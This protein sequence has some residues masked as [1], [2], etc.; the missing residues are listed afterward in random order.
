MMRRWMY[1]C[2]VVPFYAIIVY[3]LLRDVSPVML[4]GSGPMPSFYWSR[5]DP[6]P[7]VKEYSS[8]RS[9]YDFHYTVPY[10][11][12]A[13]LITSIGCGMGP[14][15]ARRVRGL[16]SHPFVGSSIATLAILLLAAL[17]SDTGDLLRLWGGPL[18][19]AHSFQTDSFV[20]LLKLLLPL[21]LLSGA[22]SF[23]ASRF[24]GTLITAQMS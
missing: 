18:M 9:Y 2:L 3:Y 5:P 12:A 22:V 20:A 13:F 11:V 8:R 15:V 7:D 19:L 21:S 24:A 23:G 1:W 4:D 10:L 17:V 14:L 16:S 6:V